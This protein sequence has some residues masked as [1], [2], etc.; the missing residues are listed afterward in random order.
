MKPLSACPT[1]A[2]AGVRLV[3]SDIDDT[4]TDDGRLGAPAY[5]A[6]HRLT[7]SGLAVVPVTG[8]PAGW[9]DAIARQ[10]PVAAVVGE[11]GAF[12]YSYDSRARRMHRHYAVSAEQRE[13]HRRR[14]EALARDILAAVPGAAIAADQP[15]R[16]ADLAIDFAE[17]VPRLDAGA[18]DRIVEM[19]EAAG[20]TAK[21][22]SIHVNG[23]FGAHDKLTTSEHLLTT[24][25]GLGPGA[26]DG[27]VAY[28]GDSPND[29]PMFK[30]FPL[31][32]GVAN[33]AE[34]GTLVD[35]PPRFITP[36]PRGAGF[37]ELAEA[38]LA[39]RG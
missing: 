11:N 2:L 7:D 5:A 32:F 13:D 1:D 29:A 34:H 27:H 31:S 19:F 23:W 26:F 21:I 17:D 28:I 36:S 33:V 4:L 10:W 38:L 22:S 18:V 14:Y 9:C 15:F 8:R 25:F 24:A 30:R 6:I 35:P 39:A 12:H 20:A 37:V 16:V 3:L